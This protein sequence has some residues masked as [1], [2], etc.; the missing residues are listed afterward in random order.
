VTTKVVD[1]GVVGCG[2]IAQAMHLPHLARLPNRFRIAAL[3]EP[4]E[5][6][7]STLGRMY[8]VEAT[9][10]SLGEL[11]GDGGVDALLVCSPNGAHAE[12]TLAAL[13]AG[14]HVFVE[15]PL[16]ITLAD[17]DRIVSA[18]NS[19]G[20]V[21]QVGYMNRFDP[22]YERMRSDLPDSA[23]DLRYVG[24]EASDPE[25]IPFF[26]PEDVVRG[27]DTPREVIDQTMAE[28]R[29]QVQ[30]AVGSSS[31]AALKAFSEGY[32]G[33]L[34]HQVNL[35]H[36][37]LEAMHEPL[38]ASVTGASWW[39]GGR[40]LSGE[41]RLGNGARWHN[42]WLQLLELHEYRERIALYFTRATQEL[43]FP[44]PWLRQSP[45]L[46]ERTARDFGGHYVQRFRSYEESYQ[47]EL[48]HFHGCVIE[49]EECRTPPEQA[50]LDIEVLTK[51]F[52]S[53]V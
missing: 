40:S 41:L 53:A 6:V 21:V 52:L 35:V 33:S 42:V 39:A 28:E 43:R 29:R 13:D 36:G 2:L 25:F 30:E 10:G 47:K 31:G 24:V 3:V 14:L 23:T 22:A 4:S 32:L 12:S 48:V 16:C 46:Y 34:V 38:P 45:T 20:R 51:M 5:I 15:K 26:G 11:L 18:R 27:E 37:L 49:E 7:R 8:G 50:R 44:S 17:A 1:V 19:S 9:Y